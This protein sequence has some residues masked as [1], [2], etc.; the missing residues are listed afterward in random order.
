MADAA[1]DD[2][3]TFVANAA[4]TGINNGEVFIVAVSV[5]AISGFRRRHIYERVY[6]GSICESPKGYSRRCL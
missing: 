5:R 1:L 3:T 4:I 6:I 2:A